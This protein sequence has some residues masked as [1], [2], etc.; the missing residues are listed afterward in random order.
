MLNVLEDFIEPGSIVAIAWSHNWKMT[1]RRYKKRRIEWMPETS[2][3]EEESCRRLQRATS[4]NSEV[5]ELENDYKIVHQTSGRQ[6]T[7]KMRE[8]LSILKDSLL[9]VENLREAELRRIF[10]SSL[11]VWN[12]LQGRIYAEEY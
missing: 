7:R 1:K 2:R 9:E 12:I 3:N 11:R 10:V 8:E 4:C 5:A 6:N